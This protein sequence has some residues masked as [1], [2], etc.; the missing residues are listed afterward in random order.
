[1]VPI[2]GI[3]LVAIDFCSWFKGLFRRIEQREYVEAFITALG[4]IG[5]F[6]PFRGRFGY[7]ALR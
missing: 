3:T 5:M 6:Q 1:M 4:V 2:V 7:G